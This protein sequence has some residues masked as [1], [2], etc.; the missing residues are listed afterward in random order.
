MLI[1]P[2]PKNEKERVQALVNLEVMDTP[3]N[4]VFERI[5]RITKQMFGVPVVAISII[6]SER[7]WFKSTQGMNVCENDLSSSFCSHAI[8]QDDVF[9]VPDSL[10]D[11]RFADNPCVEAD[12]FVRFYAGCPVQTQDGYKIG[13]LCI[14]DSKPRE[15]TEE[16][17]TSLRDMASLVQDELQKYHIKHTQ[18]EV[19]KELDKAKR[20]KLIDGLTGVWNREGTEINLRENMLLAQAQ[21]YNLV[22]GIYDIDNFK[23]VN[24]TYGHNAGDAVIREIC[25][26]MVINLDD[27]DI[28][29]RWGGE[30]FVIIAKINTN[31]DEVLKRIDNARAQ[32]CATTVAFEDKQISVSITV[33]LT[34]FDHNSNISKEELIGIAD[35][36]LYKG[37]NSG[38]NKCE[39][40]Y[41]Q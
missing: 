1:A 40:N 5:T 20:A 34:I 39:V 9:V 10:K 16:Q 24:D 41:G 35:Q 17:L 37:K 19:I 31:T 18:L 21:K 25:K 28:I 8:L 4:P 7:Q 29:G 11:P 2:K 26:T 15:F 32:V 38:K 33:G 36:A 30:E 14:I 23:H 12:P 27:N 6:D 22:V 13:T 3:I